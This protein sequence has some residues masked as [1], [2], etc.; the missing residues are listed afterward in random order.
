M[1]LFHFTTNP[2][3]FSLYVYALALVLSTWAVSRVLFERR[4]QRFQEL[5]ELPNA[6]LNKALQPRGLKRALAVVRKDD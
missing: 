5:A 6:E 1:F 4:T 3:A 2:I